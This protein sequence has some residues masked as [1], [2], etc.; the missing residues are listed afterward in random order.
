MNENN[1]D[2]EREDQ[3]NQLEPVDSN[4][5]Y[6]NGN[7]YDDAVDK[8]YDNYP[9]LISNALMAVLSQ[10]AATL[11]LTINQA[12]VLY[13][14]AI[15]ESGYDLD[16][17]IIKHMINLIKLFDHMLR[18]MKFMNEGRFQTA[19]KEYSKA[20]EFC[21]SNKK[22]LNEKVGNYDVDNSGA[23]DYLNN[24]FEIF[25]QWMFAYSIYCE[26]EILGYQGH[27]RKYIANLE[28]TII[29]L[30]STVD[31]I[32]AGV[33]VDLVQIGT[34][35]TKLADQL[36]ARA[37]AFVNL[38][39][40]T[41]FVEPDGNKIFIIHG[42]DEAKWR[43][44][45]DLLEDEFNLEVIVLKEKPGSGRVIINKFEDYAME[46]CLAFAILSPDDFVDKGE[47]KY[48]QA[49]PNV[50]FEM[51]WFFGRYGSDHLCIIK[52]VNTEIPSDLAG[53]STIEYHESI[54]EKSLAIR[55]ELQKIGLIE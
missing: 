28:K 12:E 53:I 31:N 3:S 14:E 37:E 10:D 45:R 11:R 2:S 13:T 4:L 24:F 7:L 54:T 1:N 55:K 43:E 33:S 29:T 41:K 18:A 23:I 21:K 8:F 48:M 39:N 52:N 44:L 19:K 32:P 26:G 22:E 9:V 27:T 47:N 16:L 40:V 42:H 51:G 34:M 35:I 38:A 30:R 36:E 49:R 17:I 5:D 6:N 15:R 50:L 46:S 20:S 25:G